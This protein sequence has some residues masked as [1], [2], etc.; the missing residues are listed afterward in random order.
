MMR[1]E[2][3]IPFLGPTR[4]I[5]GFRESAFQPS[6]AYDNLIELFNIGLYRAPS[7]NIT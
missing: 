2:A 4:Q 1:S 7:V 5:P 3:I 6:F